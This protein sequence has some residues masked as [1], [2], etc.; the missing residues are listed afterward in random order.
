MGFLS[1]ADNPRTPLTES[2]VV[3]IRRD[4]ERRAALLARAR[5]CNAAALGEKFGVSSR[6]IQLAVAGRTSAVGR[7]VRLDESDRALIAQ[8]YA[9]SQSLRAEARELTNRRLAEREG[10]STVTIEQIL[11]G[12]S[13]RYVA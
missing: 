3:R 7:N 9:D 8:L 1:G 6:T 4:A 2:R 10:V 5:A 11:Y 12:D 13:W